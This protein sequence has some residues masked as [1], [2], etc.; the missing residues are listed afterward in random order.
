MS[1]LPEDKCWLCGREGLHYRLFYRRLLIGQM[2]LK[3][4]GND[5][6]KEDLVDKLNQ[7]AKTT[8]PVLIAV[9]V[10]D[11][12][13]SHCPVFLRES[14]RGLT[15]GL[16]CSKCLVEH[17]LTQRPMF[18]GEVFDVEE[19]KD[20]ARAELAEEIADYLQNSLDSD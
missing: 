3:L 20:Q 15:I 14:V 10:D 12:Y 8:G 6:P 4:T 17:K 18:G 9:L 16:A 2:K 11:N 19:V 1:L 13:L 5:H 7:A